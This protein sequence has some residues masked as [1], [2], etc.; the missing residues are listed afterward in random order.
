MQRFVWIEKI[1]RKLSAFLQ[2]ELTKNYFYYMCPQASER[3]D[4]GENVK[5][6]V[7]INSNLAIGSL[8][9]EIPMA[10][11]NVISSL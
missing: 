2:L 8:I 1:Y 7:S 3:S 6:D 4:N 5:G 9:F 11:E 10:D